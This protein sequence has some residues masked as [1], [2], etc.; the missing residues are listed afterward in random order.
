[1][2]EYTICEYGSDIVLGM[3]EGQKIKMRNFLFENI[4]IVEEDAPIG[5]Q[6]LKAIDIIEELKNVPTNLKKYIH[7]VVLSPFINPKQNYYN[8]RRGRKGPIF[9]SSDHETRRITIFAIPK[10][11]SELKDTLTNHLTLSHESGHIIDGNIDPE[12]E[13]FAYT[14]RWSKAIC[15]DSKIKRT[16]SDLPLYLV[17]SNAEDL[18]SLREDF[19]DSVMYFSNEVGK[20]FLKENFPNRYKIMEELIGENG[21]IQ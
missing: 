9:A 20:E 7:S 5:T 4:T 15:E 16:R 14:P 2:P 10:E 21:A 6:K 19:A 12:M 17:S 11:R 13:C 3:P 1:M 8:N 18:E